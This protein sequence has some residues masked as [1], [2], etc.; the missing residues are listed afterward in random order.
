MTCLS[1]AS[2]LALPEDPTVWI[3]RNLLPVE[4]FLNIYA[5]PKVGKSHAALQLCEAVSNPSRGEWLT[6]PVDLHGPTLYFQID[7]PR[8]LWRLT[9]QKLISKGF[10]FDDVA[11]ADR[12]LAPFPFDIL[13]EGGAFV[14]E[15]VLQHRPV[16]VVFD[17]LR[18]IHQQNENDSQEMKR[19]LD[20]LI[21]ATPG[22]ARVLISHAKKP[23]TS[24]SGTAHA[25]SLMNDNRGSSYIPGKMDGIVKL[26]PRKLTWQ[27]R[28]APEAIVPLTSQE[29]VLSPADGV[30]RLAADLITGSL[31]AGDAVNQRDLARQLHAAHPGRSEESLRSLVRR[32]H[33]DITSG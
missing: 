21:L 5:L 12:Q 15:S 14:H 2:Y 4:G 29:G 17:T 8:G 27:S 22:C 31:A 26:A 23:S 18:E 19:V 13:G 9:C 16:L 25:T 3:L 6:F 7:A 28:S 10:V 11:V 32:L 1:M 33:H 20:A 24:P 30:E